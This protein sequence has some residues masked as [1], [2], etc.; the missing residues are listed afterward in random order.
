M[1]VK[2][3]EPSIPGQS[4]R[5]VFIQDMVESGAFEAHA[6]K[7]FGE[8][9]K[10]ATKAYN[11]PEFIA[12]KELYDEAIFL[13]AQS[14]GVGND[15]GVSYN[16]GLAYMDLSKKASEAS[17]ERADE[18]RDEAIQAFTKVLEYG[19]VDAAIKA[20]A[21]SFLNEQTKEQNMSKTL[22]LEKGLKEAQQN[23]VESHLS[24][25][26]SYT[27]SL[28]ANEDYPE[29]AYFQMG[30]SYQA[31]IGSNPKHKDNAIQSYLNAIALYTS[32]QYNGCEQHRD[33]CYFAATISAD[34][35]NEAYAKGI[36]SQAIISAETVIAY[37]GEYNS[38]RGVNGEFTEKTVQDAR[39]TKGASLYMK[40]RY[41][42]ALDTYN[43]AASEHASDAEY[44]ER[45]TT[46]KAKV[47]NDW[48]ELRITPLLADGKTEEAH[49]EY[50]K[51]LARDPSDTRAGEGIAALREKATGS[52]HSS[53]SR[54]SSKE[55]LSELSRTASK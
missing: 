27:T 55:S 17:A 40:G 38:L 47:V 10:I 36:Y 18:Y 6:R 45:L 21:L 23:T 35:A 48:H 44:V 26:S 16:L 19:D 39:F 32:G 31:L 28:S 11:K 2:L 1:F 54:V 49:K 43:H 14:Y 4:R 33:A 3:T 15:H 20:D 9:V 37:A 42:E 24:A 52:P 7:C 41:G 13:Y 5:A 29:S 8:A 46:E 53:V 30:N 51:I 25:I 34:K 22:Y 50:R 12:A